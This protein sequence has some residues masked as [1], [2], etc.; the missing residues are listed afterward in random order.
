MNKCAKILLIVIFLLL[1]LPSSVATGQYP[2]QQYTT[3]DNNAWMVGGRLQV[4]QTFTLPSDSI[5]QGVRVKVY[6][7]RFPGTV[8]VSIKRAS[9]IPYGPDLVSGEF[10][11]NSLPT[12]ANEAIWITV[13]LD[14]TP[15]SAGRYA[16]V[17]KAPGG[18]LYIETIRWRQD[19]SGEY[20]GGHIHASE[21]DGARW[22]LYYS[23]NQIRDLMFEVI[24][25]IQ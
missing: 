4:A 14:D 21:D 23:N 12:Q 11:A 6:R 7:G 24:G 10:E 15:V 17:M 22:N 19:L 25:S 18:S 13:F 5:I 16:I 8:T 3:G 9:V 20:P 2:L 1:L